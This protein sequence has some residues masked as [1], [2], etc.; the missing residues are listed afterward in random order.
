MK[1]TVTIFLFLLS[2]SLISINAY[3]QS[4]PIVLHPDREV[5]EPRSIFLNPPKYI[6]SF[7]PEGHQNSPLSVDWVQYIDTV[8]GQFAYTGI[9]ATITVSTGGTPPTFLDTIVGY[10]E[11]FTS[12]YNSTTYLDS[13]QVGIAI[14]T[15]ALTANN[16][17]YRLI[18]AAYT[19]T[20]G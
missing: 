6:R 8:D 17:S 15:G 16:N 3:A 9:P 19:Q 10:S 7:L 11:R 4:S 18:I 2:A 1:K 20:L 14:P 13:V 5:V 12:P